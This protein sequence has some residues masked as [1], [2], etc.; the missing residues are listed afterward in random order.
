MPLPFPW[1]F[2]ERPSIFYKA[3]STIT[4]GLVGSVSKLWMSE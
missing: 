3:I 2:P 1:P 4:I